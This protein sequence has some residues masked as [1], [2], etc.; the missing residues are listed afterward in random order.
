LIDLTNRN[1]TDLDSQIAYT[2]TH[3]EYIHFEN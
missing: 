3:F 1:I 2:L